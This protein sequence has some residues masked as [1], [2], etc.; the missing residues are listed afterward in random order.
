MTI[1]ERLKEERSRLGLSQTD[2]GAAGGVGKTTQLNYEKDE[3]SPDAKYLASVKPLGID[4]YYVLVGERF[5]VSPD[6]LSPFELEVMSYLKE[7]TDYD[8]ETLRRMA[9]AMATVTKGST[10]TPDS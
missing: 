7:L 2:L 5:P 4:V 9:A 10:A 8:K 3:R 1:G 6:Q